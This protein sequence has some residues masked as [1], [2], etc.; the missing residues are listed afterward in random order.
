M[1]TFSPNHGSAVVK[2]GQDTV[3]SK[4]SMK[5]L[6]YMLGPDAAAQVAHL[7]G[8]FSR[9]FWNLLV[10]LRRFGLKGN[11]LFRLYCALVRQVLGTNGVV[12]H[13][14]LS[15]AQNDDPERLQKLV[16]QLC[17]SR[18][19]RVNQEMAIRETRASEDLQPRS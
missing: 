12:F 18:A 7:K 3:T 15:G 6:G 17:Y 1:I 13:P 9:R 11:R 10:H 4:S 2:F 5:L 19:G 14:M 16:L 8:K